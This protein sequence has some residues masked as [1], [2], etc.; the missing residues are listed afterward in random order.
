MHRGGLG[1]AGNREKKSRLI[2]KM[3]ALAEIV[4]ETDLVS[5]PVKACTYQSLFLILIK[6]LHGQ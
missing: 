5:W 1:R 4:Q 6:N 2:Q 3:L